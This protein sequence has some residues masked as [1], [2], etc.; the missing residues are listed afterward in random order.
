MS[1]EHFDNFMGY[2]QQF[3][4]ESEEMA[5]SN[6]ELNEL[7]KKDRCWLEGFANGLHEGGML[8]TEELGVVSAELMSMIDN[9][10]K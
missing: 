3:F 9:E 1:T 10:D 4:N 8:T 2:A 5:T 7:Y 6:K